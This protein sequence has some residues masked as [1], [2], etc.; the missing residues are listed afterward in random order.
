MK[1]DK[2]VLEIDFDREKLT[3]T[4]LEFAVSDTLLFFSDK[5]EIFEKQNELWLP[6][7]SLLEDFLETKIF[8]TSTLIVPIQNDEFFINLKS[9]IYLLSNRDFLLL[10]S[11]A[12]HT[13]SVLLALM[14]VYR[15][16]DAKKAFELSFLE[17]ICQAKIWGEIIEAV[18]MRE[19]TLQDLLNIEDCLNG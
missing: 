10:Y 2:S 18:S 17:E 11:F 14:F 7:I 1:I 5:P 19:K 16:I 3:A 4:L 6:A 8:Y 13:R 9:K 12:L 15:K